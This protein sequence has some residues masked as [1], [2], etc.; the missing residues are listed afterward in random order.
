MGD[1]RLFGQ[2]PDLFD[3]FKSELLPRIGSFTYPPI[4]VTE[5]ADELVIRA[6][7][8]GIDPKNLDVEIGESAIVLRGKADEARE[9]TSQGY[10]RLERRSGSF[11]RM[12]SY[13]IPVLHQE[14]KASLRNGLLE[15]KIPKDKTKYRGMRKLAIEFDQ[16]QN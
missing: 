4:D 9:V 14:A 5:T 6:E 11:E 16:N 8:P 15:I 10:R 3:A 2:F 1:L 7:V 13:P 12:I